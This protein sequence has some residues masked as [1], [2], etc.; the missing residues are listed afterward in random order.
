MN[1]PKRR[2]G[3]RYDGYRIR[4]LDPVF[5]VI[6]AV[7]RTRV[8]SQVF[9]DYELD[10]TELEKFVREHRR[11]DIPDLRMLH[12]FMASMVRIMALMP[13]L[14]RFVAGRKIYARNSMRIS[15]ACKRSMSIDDE[16]TTIMPE[17]EPED[18]LY[19]VVEKVEKAI[20]EDVFENQVEGNKT[21]VV[22]RVLGAIP[23]FIKAGFV[24][25]M[26]N[27]DKIGW[28]P[29]FINNA[30]PFHSSMFIT[31]LGSCGI[32]PIYHHLY[33]FGTC[34]VFV[35]M[36][37]KDTRYEL[38]AKGNVVTKRYIGM[39]VVADERICDGFYYAS[40]MKML[41]RLIKHPERLL[42]K[43]QEVVYDSIGKHKMAKKELA[44]AVS[45]D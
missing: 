13:R 8:D 15:L 14:N 9:F 18:T 20:R 17:F 21:D 12:I 4:G 2:F 40:A 10:I 16:E 44:A 41:I 11:S 6:P 43:P 39:K 22:A 24:D 33:E 31:D 7:M 27:L 38:D 30:S 37:K 5:E 42:E 23:T 28:M 19:D 35:A 36:G 45:E 29:K 32:G 3:D 1:K 26:R 25:L 34:S